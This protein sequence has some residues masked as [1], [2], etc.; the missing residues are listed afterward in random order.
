MVHAFRR[1]LVALGELGREAQKAILARRSNA[2]IRTSPVVSFEGSPAGQ[3][4]LHSGRPRTTSRIL[5]SSDDM[6]FELEPLNIAK[7]E[8]DP[9]FFRANS[10]RIALDFLG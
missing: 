1:A 6:S 4:Q 2:A 7:K 5:T 9:R 10:V 8:Y 3:A